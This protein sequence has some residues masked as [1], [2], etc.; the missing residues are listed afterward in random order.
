MTNPEVS[1][2]MS[3]S[4]DRVK[5][6]VSSILKKLEASNRTEAVQIATRCGIL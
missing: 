3:V 6:L 1:E 4:K 5:E 2:L